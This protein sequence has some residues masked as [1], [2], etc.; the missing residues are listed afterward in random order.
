MERG[1]CGVQQ[2][3]L[4]PVPSRHFSCVAEK[5]DHFRIALTRSGEQ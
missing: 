1:K 5:S 2:Y 3:L 4:E